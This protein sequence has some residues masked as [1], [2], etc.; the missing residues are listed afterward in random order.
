[1]LVPWDMLIIF[2][3]VQYDIKEFLDQNHKCFACLS[4][5]HVSIHQWNFQR[6]NWLQFPGWLEKQLGIQQAPWA[7]RQHDIW[8]RFQILHIELHVGNCVLLHKFLMFPSLATQLWTPAYKYI[9]SVNGK[10]RYPSWAQSIISM[11]QDRALLFYC[12]SS[13]LR[14]RHWWR[15]KK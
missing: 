8:Q 14:T 13:K 3:W 4:L 10:P 11:G 12:A 15:R 7:E 6:H 1:M 5:Y 2:F 9:D